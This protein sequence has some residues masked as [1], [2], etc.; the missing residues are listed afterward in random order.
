MSY[1]ASK[2]H[3]VGVRYD[4]DGQLEVVAPFGLDD[5]FAFRITP[6]RL[7]DN[8][9]THEAKGARAKACWPEI[10]VVPW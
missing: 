9:R 7:M 5:L 4:A 8:R 1:F 3:A 2:T 10:T 6:N